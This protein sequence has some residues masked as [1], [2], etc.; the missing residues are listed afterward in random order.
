[1]RPLDHREPGIVGT[2]LDTESHFAEIICDG[3]HVAP[4]LIRLWLALKRDHAILVTDAISA[5]GMPDGQY[6][7]GPIAVTVKG[8]RCT[9]ANHPETS[10]AP[11]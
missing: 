11:S 7:L 1:M 4:E 5:T 2:V 8:D 9:L 6:S 3:V 10:P